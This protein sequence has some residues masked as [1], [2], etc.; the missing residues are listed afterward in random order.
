MS[1]SICLGDFNEAVSVPCGHAFC[2]ECL[3]GHIET[4]MENAAEE[5]TVVLC[6]DCRAPFK[7]VM[8]EH[9]LIPKHLRPFVQPSVRR[10]YLN[11]PEDTTNRI[12]ALER[13]KQ[14]LLASCER[15]MGAAARHREGERAQRTRAQ[16]LE[17]ELQ[18]TKDRLMGIIET[19]D[20]RLF[21]MQRKVRALEITVQQKEDD[22]ARMRTTVYSVHAEANESRGERKKRKIISPIGSATSEDERDEPPVRRARKSLPRRAAPSHPIQVQDRLSTALE[23]YYKKTRSK[24]GPFVVPI[25]QP[26]SA[27]QIPCTLVPPNRRK[28][29][30]QQ[31]GL[32]VGRADASTTSAPDRSVEAGPSTSR[33][34]VYIVSDSSDDEAPPLFGRTST[35]Q[36]HIPWRVAPKLSALPKRRRVERVDDSDSFDSENDTDDDLSEMYPGRIPMLAASPNRSR[37]F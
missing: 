23:E 6:P 31:E 7:T 27:S 10:L 8:P 25:A 24:G 21:E 9:H 2:L 35:R 1:C 13:D 12:K 19:Y 36:D 4:S 16:E 18:S 5:T 34:T 15:H 20:E 11:A 33:R 22:L 29:S 3:N 17:E 37:R 26:P 14:Q 28:K 32:S 30:K